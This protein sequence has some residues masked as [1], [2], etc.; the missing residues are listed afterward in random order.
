[1]SVLGRQLFKAPYG[2]HRVLPLFKTQ[3]CPISVALN[4]LRGI[5]STSRLLLKNEFTVKDADHRNT[6]DSPEPVESVDCPEGF[7]P[8]KYILEEMLPDYQKWGWAI[9]RT[10]FGNDEK[11]E[12]CNSIIQHMVRPAPEDWTDHPYHPHLKHLHF[13]VIDDPKF[14]GATTVQLREHFKQWRREQLLLEPSVQWAL[15]RNPK[16]LEQSIADI[17]Y[18]LFIRVNQESMESILS[19]DPIGSF[20][21]VD[22]VEWAWEEPP[23]ERNG[24]WPDIEGLTCMDIGFRRISIDNLYPTYWVHWDLGLCSGAYQRPPDI[25]KFLDSDYC[26]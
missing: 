9:Y 3:T 21:W 1:M 6:A 7:R 25:T 14:E 26:F 8:A 18:Q 20:G 13:P 19:P 16:Y 22:V 23:W 15:S 24:G 5:S 12:K 4:S 2:C 11:W 10:A 17:Q